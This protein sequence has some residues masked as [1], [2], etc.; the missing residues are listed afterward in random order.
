MESYYFDTILILILIII[1]VI[2]DVRLIKI[3]VSVLIIFN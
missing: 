3:R 2:M 1:S